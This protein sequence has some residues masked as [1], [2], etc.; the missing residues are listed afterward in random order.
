[1]NRPDL[2]PLLAAVALLL[3]SALA[4]CSVPLAPGYRI[5]SESREIHFVSG[6]VPSLEIRAHYVLGNSGTQPLASLDVVFPLEKPYGL[7]NVRAQVNDR[8]TALAPL[9]AEFRQD[10]PDALRMA[11]DPPWTQRS[12]LD[13]AISYSFVSPGEG[14]ERITLSRD[15]FHLGSRG[16][17][18][19][20]QPPAHVLSPYPKRPDRTSYTIRVPDDFLVLARGTLRSRKKIGKESE[21]H[22][23]LRKDDLTPFVVAGRY[24]ETAP[25]GKDGVIFWT[26]HSLADP[27][28]AAGAA[29]KIA[30]DWSTLSSAF[31]PLDKTIREPHIVESSSVR[32]DSFGET[33]AAAAAF[34][35]GAL[36]SPAAVASGI[37]SG[38][39]LD[40]V[41]SAL[42]RNWFGGQMYFA[43]DAAIGMGEG[44]PSYA[45]IVMEEAGT[46]ATARQHRVVGFMR[47]Y[48]DALKQGPETPLGIVS[49]AD[50][51]AQRRIAY[52]KA[53]LMYA[54]L[55]DAYGEAAVRAALAR[56]VLLFRGQ[57]VS[58]AEL[59]AVIEERTGK[60]LAVF[61]RTWLYG[62][63]LPP[64]F[65]ARYA[66]SDETQR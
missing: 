38:V 27:A 39:F 60:D 51:P 28:A 37:D 3:L 5:L 6:G 42:A 1:M 43:P 19:L 53:P 33:G 65:R 59:R 25:N 29:N 35:G 22:F 62:K 46:G 23:E 11:L 8:D 40:A 55:E 7:G 9:P 64:N 50:P 63:G 24:V 4:A 52:A 34:P 31:G 12:K 49:A 66:A 54:A 15:D 48:D 17:F 10:R 41:S 56:L 47:A 16:W 58:Y 45:T 61:F 20:P 13:L 21:Y 44:L 2:P 30:S 57:E 36:V 26:R 18:A 14:G 32:E